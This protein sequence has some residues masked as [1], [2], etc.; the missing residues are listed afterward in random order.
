M[1][2]LGIAPCSQRLQHLFSLESSTFIVIVSVGPSPTS[3]CAWDLFAGNRHLDGIQWLCAWA[4]EC[5]LKVRLV[6]YVGHQVL[7]GELILLPLQSRSLCW[8]LEAHSSD[9]EKHD[10]RPQ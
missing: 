7:R 3:S 5:R 6:G 8:C 4:H 10:L 9:S 1:E 2:P